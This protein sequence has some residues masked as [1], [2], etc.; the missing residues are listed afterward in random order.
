M[1]AAAAN[2][3]RNQ[4]MGLAPFLVG[5][6]FGRFEVGPVYTPGT[7]TVVQQHPGA[8]HVGADASRFTPEDLGRKIEW[9]ADDLYFP[10]RRLRVE[11]CLD[12]RSA[13]PD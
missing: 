10:F 13:G 3:L 6:P 1:T 9:R 11:P 12:A 8:V 4:T 5:F 7:A 2:T